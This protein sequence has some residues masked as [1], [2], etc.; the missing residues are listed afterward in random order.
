MRLQKLH[1]SDTPNVKGRHAHLY[2]VV[3]G[4]VQGKW[5]FAGDFPDNCYSL[6]AVCVTRAQVKVHILPVHSAGLGDC[7]WLREVPA[8]VHFLVLD[9]NG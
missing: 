3:E 4:L 5:I 9:H 7:P 2:R 1:W 6:Y 8:C